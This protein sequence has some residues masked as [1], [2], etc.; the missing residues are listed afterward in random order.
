[1]E[2]IWKTLV[3]RGNVFSRYEVSTNGN[4]RSKRTGNVRKQQVD[5]K[6]YARITILDDSGNQKCVSIHGCV[7][8]TFIPNPENKETVNHIDG[9]KLNNCVENLEWATQKE[10]GWHATNVLGYKN[11]YATSMRERF[12]K[13]VGQYSEDGI[14]LHMWNST[15]EVENILGFCHESIA[16]CARGKRHKAYGYLW[17]YE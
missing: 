17:R 2:E 5:R 1:M 6:G 8:S 11:Y 15:R 3:Y 7:A 10:Q 13:K 14:L 16:S 9:N 4:V 12:S